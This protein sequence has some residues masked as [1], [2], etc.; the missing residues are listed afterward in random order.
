MTDMTKIMYSKKDREFD[1]YDKLLEMMRSEFNE[2]CSITDGHLYCTD[3][4]DLYQVFLDNLPKDAVQH[5]TCNVCR[6]FVNK[7]GRLVTIMENG[8]LIPAIWPEYGPG[9]FDAAV[10]AVREHLT[11]K[12]KVISVFY[13][14]RTDLGTPQTG[15]WCHMSVNLNNRLLMKAHPGVY[16]NCGEKISASQNDYA[17]VWRA[18]ND[19]SIDVV[20]EA[21]KL[22]NSGALF[23]SDKVRNTCSAFLNLLNDINGEIPA[24]KT[25]KVW[26]YVASATDP[27]YLH[28]RSSVI[29]TLLDDIKDGVDMDTII[30]KFNDKMDPMKYQ[31]P[32]AA[33]ST[34]NIERAEQLFKEL[35]FTSKSLERRYATLEDLEPFWTPD[36]TTDVK[37]ESEEVF[38]RLKSFAKDAPKTTKID[39]IIDRGVMTWNKFYNEILPYTK[40]IKLNNASRIPSDY[41]STFLTAVYPDEKCIFKYGNHVSYYMYAN[42]NDI[43]NI[44]IFGDLNGKEITAIC[45]DPIAW[46][47]SNMLESSTIGV[48]LIVEGAKDLA[49][50]KNGLHGTA[51][52]PEDL[53][54]ELREV[55]STVE[56]Y[57]S[58]DTIKGA[59]SASATGIRIQRGVNYGRTINLIVDTDTMG[60]L[61]LYI[62]RWE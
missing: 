26:R 60:T 45:Y 33:P 5:Y 15:E 51:I 55:R 58:T 40:S 43:N 24:V 7:Y 27:G 50:I 10:A 38:G 4:T 8:E 41:I 29:G 2:I 28:I 13:T 61:S 32:Q 11:T 35:G 57:S 48:N 42:N 47:N 37:E 39:S 12:A 30:K 56:S 6:R 34:G 21:M 3:A 52:F 46:G 44:I 49:A 23:R 1:E 16:G 22:I 62:D 9:I 54:P 53:I 36:D 17:T 31:R 59:D 19:Y 14:D 25:A 18:I 20:R